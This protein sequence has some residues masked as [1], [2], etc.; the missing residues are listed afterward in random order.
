MQ[1]YTETITRLKELEDE[2]ILNFP[3][4]NREIDQLFERLSRQVQLIAELEINAALRLRD[5][6]RPK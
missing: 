1:T 5:V 3:L 6:T 4:E 2:I